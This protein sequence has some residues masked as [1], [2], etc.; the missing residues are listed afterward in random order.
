[1][2]KLREHGFR[3]AGLFAHHKIRNI[4]NLNGALI[5]SVSTSPLHRH[6]GLFAHHIIQESECSIYASPL[7]RH[8]GLFTDHNIRNINSL[9]IPPPYLPLLH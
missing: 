5:L 7:Y 2:L 9:D 1:M 6:A 3:H 8:A 4:T